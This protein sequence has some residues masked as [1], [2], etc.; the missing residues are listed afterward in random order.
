MVSISQLG[1]VRPIS[2]RAGEVHVTGGGPE[3]PKE[4]ATNWQCQESNP[5]LPTPHPFLIL[6]DGDGGFTRRQ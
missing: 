5:Q 1:T 6:L 3:K 4:T 2:Q